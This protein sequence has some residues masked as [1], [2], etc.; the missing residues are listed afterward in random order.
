MRHRRLGKSMKKRVAASQEWRCAK[1]TKILPP[2]F[3]VDHVFPHSLGGTDH[4]CN[5]EALC[6]ECHAAKSQIE[7]ARIAHHKKLEK[8]CLSDRHSVPCW[9]CHRIVSTYFTHTCDYRGENG[10]YDNM[11]EDMYEDI[12][13]AA[14]E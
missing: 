12:A 2:T 10:L 14:A 5:L 9:T 1:C 11:Y 4:P 7:Q 3:Q 8:R 6:V 13:Q